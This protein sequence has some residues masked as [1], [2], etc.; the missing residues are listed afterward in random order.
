MATLPLQHTNEE[1]GVMMTNKS[2]GK[3]EL[4]TA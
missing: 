4:G 3:Q 2:Q 1:A